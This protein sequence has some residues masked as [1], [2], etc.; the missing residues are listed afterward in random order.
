MK[1]EQEQKAKSRYTDLVW[2][3]TPPFESN[4]LCR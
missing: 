1:Q 2:Q 4:S 3:V